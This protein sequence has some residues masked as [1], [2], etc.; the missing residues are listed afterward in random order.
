MPQVHFL[1]TRVSFCLSKAKNSEKSN[2][3]GRVSPV[4]VKS[5]GH[6]RRSTSRSESTED[7]LERIQELVE[8]IGYARV[9]DVAE[10]LKLSRSTVSNMVR[11]LAKRG[12]LNYQRYRGFTLTSEGHAIANHIKERH[13]LLAELLGMLGLESETVT[14]EVEDIEHH[15]KPQ[16][17]L[18]LSSLVDFWRGH[19]EELQRYLTFRKRRL[20]LSSALLGKGDD[21]ESRA[22][23]I[24]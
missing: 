20:F 24:V 11:R 9:S 8:E 17:M 19:P 5:P 23:P 3:L 10:A 7:H 4:R 18:A 12:Y 21:V 16:T 13:R 1:A 15:L 14:Q 22:T 6:R 2:A